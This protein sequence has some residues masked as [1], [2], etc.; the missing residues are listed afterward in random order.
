[1]KT[2]VVLSALGL[3][4]VLPEVSQ[5]AAGDKAPAPPQVATQGVAKAKSRA[6]T[7]IVPAVAGR[8][9]LVC[10]TCGGA[11][12]NHVATGNLGGFN[13]VWEFG[14]GCGSGQTWRWDN[15]PYFCSN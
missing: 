14:S 4:L 13:W 11:Y 12:P 3:A 9:V 6:S 8:A 7:A 10:Y 15:T 5:A 2:F 1:M